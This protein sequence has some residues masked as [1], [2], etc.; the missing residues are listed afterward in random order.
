MNSPQYSLWDNQHS[1]TIFV[2][3]M[4]NS[5]MKKYSNFS[6]YYKILIVSILKYIKEKLKIFRL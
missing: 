1:E 4:I 5:S 2:C 6:N 3:V